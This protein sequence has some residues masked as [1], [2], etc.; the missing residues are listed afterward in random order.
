MRHTYKVK[1]KD[2]YNLNCIKFSTEGN[3][4]EAVRYLVH[5]TLKTSNINIEQSSFIVYECTR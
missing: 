2:S 4:N 3:P 1:K 5:A